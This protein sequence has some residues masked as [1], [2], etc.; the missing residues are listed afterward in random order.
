[1]TRHSYTLLIAAFLI[2]SGCNRSI[3]GQTD[4]VSTYDQ[5]GSS[6]TPEGALPVQ[7][8]MADAAQLAGG[9]VKVEGVIAE[10]CQ[11]AGCWLTMATAEGELL[12]VDV[13]R[14]SSGAYVYTFP[15]DISGRRVIVAGPLSSGE[16]SSHDDHHSEEAHSE[17]EAEVMEQTGLVL[18]ASGA[19]VER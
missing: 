5:F 14:D 2:L 10:V 16:E 9:T 4:P 15:K 3:E 8:V 17:Q 11:N 13:P 6:T 1:M 7:A 12:R 18:V 19:L